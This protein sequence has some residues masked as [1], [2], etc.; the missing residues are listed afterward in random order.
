MENI[1]LKMA[2]NK[3]LPKITLLLYIAG[4]L[5]IAVF[6]FRYAVMWIDYSQAFM[7]GAIGV[8][9]VACGYIHAEFVAHEQRIKELEDEMMD[10]AGVLMELRR[11]LEAN[12]LIE[13]VAE[14]A[15]PEEVKA[16]AWDKLG[17]E[18]GRE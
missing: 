4:C 3:H 12:D 5:W 17:G 7:F 15:R 6:A 8:G 1:D 18:H 11:E 9:M 13:K 2:W 14:V 10:F 16:G